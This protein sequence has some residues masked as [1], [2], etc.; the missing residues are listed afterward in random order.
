MTVIRPQKS[1]AVVQTYES[2]AYFSWGASI[3]GL[4]LELSFAY[5]DAAEFESLDALYRADAAIVFDPQD[6]SS[7]PV[8]YNVEM[9]KL[10]CKYYLAL[11]KTAGNCRKNVTV[12]LLVLSEA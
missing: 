12:T 5:M 4:E 11:D 7:P 1:C 8:T 6:G 9:T 10:D 2:A 3:V